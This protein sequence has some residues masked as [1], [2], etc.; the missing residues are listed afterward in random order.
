MCEIKLKEKIQG[1]GQLVG[2]IHRINAQQNLQECLIHWIFITEIRWDWKLKGH[3]QDKCPL[4]KKHLPSEGTW[5]WMAHTVKDWIHLILA[6][7][8]ERFVYAI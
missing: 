2:R 3:K 1:K 8:M 7:L 4:M 6:C 5:D